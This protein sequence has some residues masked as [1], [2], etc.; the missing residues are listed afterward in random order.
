MTIL[1]R[2]DVHVGAGF[3]DSI[4]W[5]IE[6]HMGEKDTGEFNYGILHGNE[7]A[8]LKIDLWRKD[9]EWRDPPDRSWDPTKQLTPDQSYE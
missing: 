3:F 8:P 6:T 5:A 4:K 7:D 1:R 9:P 2:Q